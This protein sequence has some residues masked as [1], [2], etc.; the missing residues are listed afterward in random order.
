MNNG[1]LSVWDWGTIYETPNF[2]RDFISE[3]PYYSL[4]FFELMLLSYVS[5]FMP[6]IL[7]YTLLA[8]LEFGWNKAKYLK[9]DILN[10]KSCTPVDVVAHYNGAI[11]SSYPSIKSAGYAVGIKSSKSVLQH[12]QERTVITNPKYHTDVRLQRGK[13]N[14]YPT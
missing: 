4:T 1:G 8:N 3:Y 7:E 13:K 5:Q 2:L 11:L 14:K 10:Y 12:V 9:F 6:R